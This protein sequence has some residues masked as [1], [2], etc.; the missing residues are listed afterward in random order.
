MK[1]KTATECWTIL[2]SELDSAIDRYVSMTTQGKRSN[3]THLSKEA[4]R[5]I[6]YKQAM[7]RV[8]KHAGKDKDYEVYKKALHEATNEVRK[9]TRNCEHKLAQ[10]IKSDSNNFYSYVRSKQNVRDKVGP[11]EDNAGNK[12]TEGFL[13]AEELNMHFSSMF[14]RKNT[15]SFITTTR[16]KAQWI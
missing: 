13:M 8:Y 6:R 3:K 14:T 12:I 5:K 1:N 10:H 16:N 11:L 2:R 9:S 4:F 15:S 7:W